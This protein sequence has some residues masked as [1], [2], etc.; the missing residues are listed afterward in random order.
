MTEACKIKNKCEVTVKR[1]YKNQAEV[2]CG[3][4]DGTEGH[5][6]KLNEPDTERQV[7]HIFHMC[8]LKLLIL[9]QRRAKQ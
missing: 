3:E 7:L 2:I 9:K 5:Y 6:A 1:K 8:K 4:V